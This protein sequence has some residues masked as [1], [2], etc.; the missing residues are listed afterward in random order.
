[1]WKGKELGLKDE[2]T[3]GM[4]SRGHKSNIRKPETIEIVSV[5]LKVGWVKHHI[6]TNCDKQNNRKV[7]IRVITE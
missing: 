2:K 6:M 7:S 1:L 4:E 3:R 5:H